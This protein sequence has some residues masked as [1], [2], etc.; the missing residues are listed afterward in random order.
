MSLRRVSPRTTQTYN[1]DVVYPATGDQLAP[2]V[3][4]TA[5]DSALDNPIPNSP[6]SADVIELDPSSASRD[7]AL[8]EG[9]LD[10]RHR[11]SDDRRLDTRPRGSDD[12]RLD[13]RHRASDDRRLDTRHHGSDDRRLDTRHRGT[14]DRRLDTRHRGS[15]DRRLD[16]RHRGSDDRRLDTRHRGSDDRR[17]DTRHRGSDDRRLDT[18]HRGSDDRRLDTRHRGT[19][20]RR[21]DTEHRASDKRRLDTRDR[22][23]A[24]SQHGSLLWPGF[25]GVAVFLVLLPTA[26]VITVVIYNR[27]LPPT[28]E[29]PRA[30]RNSKRDH[31]H[32]VNLYA[33]DLDR[34][35]RRLR[36][37]IPKRRSTVTVKWWYPFIGTGL[38]VGKPKAQ[39]VE[40][41]Y[42]HGIRSGIL[43]RQRS[44]R[45]VRRWLSSLD[46]LPAGP[47]PPT[48]VR[49]A[50]FTCRHVGGCG[51]TI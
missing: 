4:K 39:K 47:D 43:Q 22:F 41:R 3:Q 38:T 28:P 1:S 42:K 10:T 25:S 7:R 44:R 11:G 46:A 5:V 30:P 49:P 33:N 50:V 16:T 8:D 13:T 18:R 32:S 20:V 27:P 19:D 51:P 45:I 35:L 15:D 24:I 17:L 34:Y 12:R 31:R 37:R 14:D 26:F 23:T 48:T 40:E 2:D 9:R 36:L 29:L 6:R 21:L